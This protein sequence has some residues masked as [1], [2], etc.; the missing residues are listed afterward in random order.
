M[1]SSEIVDYEKGR[2]YA[3][4]IWKQ[5]KTINNAIDCLHSQGCSGLE[6]FDQIA[7]GT[8]PKKSDILDLKSRLDKAVDHLYENHVEKRRITKHFLKCQQMCIDCMQEVY[9]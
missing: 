8:T 9:S 5:I 3:T 6:K 1:S 4:K 7:P 2:E